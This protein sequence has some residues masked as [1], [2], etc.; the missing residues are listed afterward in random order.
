MYY[1]V[2]ALVAMQEGC[3]VLLQSEVGVHQCDPLG[4]ALFALTIHP[5]LVNLQNIYPEI[6]ALAYLDDVFLVGAPTDVINAFNCLSVCLQEL[7]L[8]I[9]HDKCDLYC[10]DLN[11][12]IPDCPVPVKFDGIA[13]LGLPIGT[14]NFVSSYCS[15]FADSGN[16]LCDQL[17]ALND[18][19]SASLLLRYCHV[20]RLNHLA[21]TVCPS[22]LSE[23]TEIHDLQ[24]RSVFFNLLS[25]DHLSDSV[26]WQASLP[27]RLG[28]FGLS[29]VK[30]VSPCAFLASWVQALVCLLIRFPNLKSF[31][32]SFLASP[33]EFPT[34]I[35][36]SSLIPAASKLSD[37]LPENNKLQKKLSSEL[38]ESL[39]SNVLKASV[40]MRD[41]ARFCSLTSKGAGAWISAVPSS[42][43]FT[44][45]SC[46]YRSLGVEAEVRFAGLLI[47]M[48]K[49]M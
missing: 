39:L 38:A 29:S 45:D 40:S 20:P 1:D 15:S 46:V 8:N 25:Y 24:T 32:D 23:T 35:V 5:S 18:V 7:G 19:Q 4:P 28:G 30:S 27:I 42:A 12:S 14:A 43:C 16:C 10:P 44:I 41:A 6:Q 26:W 33:S 47:R 17:V 9:R 37:Y 11:I 49:I 3:P 2:G 21:T 31:I 36:L 34:G 13:I 48:V 22:L